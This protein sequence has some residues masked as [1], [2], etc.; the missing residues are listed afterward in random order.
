MHYLFTLCTV[1]SMFAIPW[2]ISEGTV[3]DQLQ[4]FQSFRYLHD[5]S[6]LLIN[7]GE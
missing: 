3:K 1:I 2:Q 6:K 7:L 5:E 4:E